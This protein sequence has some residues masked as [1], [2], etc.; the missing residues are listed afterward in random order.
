M[1][2]PPTP[3]PPLHRI[4]GRNAVSPLRWD[5]GWVWTTQCGH[6]Q[7]PPTPALASKHRAESSST[8]T[9]PSLAPGLPSAMHI[10]TQE[11]EAGGIQRARGGLAKT[12]VPILSCTKASLRSASPWLAHSTGSTSI[13]W[14]MKCTFAGQLSY[15]HRDRFPPVFVLNS[16]V[17]CSCSNGAETGD[18]TWQAAPG[19]GVPAGLAFIL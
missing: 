2:L 16:R 17:L 10:L 1:S 15:I 8:P 4:Q 7:H 6:A 5:L 9:D 11:S 12:T 13:L 3:P 19:C 14:V 18:K